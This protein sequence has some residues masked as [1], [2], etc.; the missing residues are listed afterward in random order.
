MVLRRSADGSQAVPAS[1]RIQRAARVRTPLFPSAGRH[2]KAVDVALVVALIGWVVVAWA[3]NRR[4][5]PVAQPAHRLTVTSDPFGAFNPVGAHGHLG[6]RAY[7]QPLLRS[8]HQLQDGVDVGV[9]RRSYSALLAAASP[10]FARTN[11]AA[12]DIRCA[13]DVAT[14]ADA[15]WDRYT[16]VGEAWRRCSPRC[17]GARLAPSLRPRVDAAGA[18]LAEA[19][20]GLVALEQ[21]GVSLHRAR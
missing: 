21:P 8:L 19:D 11:F 10:V 6:C 5:G 1:V 13:I 16:R 9:D 7:L 2:A 20:R 18:E 3:L 15:A 4:S 14:P 17:T 12:V